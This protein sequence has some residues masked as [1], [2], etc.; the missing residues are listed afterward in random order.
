MLKMLYILQSKDF[1]QDLIIYGTIPIHL[2]SLYI[3]FIYM[4]T[5]ELFRYV[6][7]YDLLSVN[8]ICILIWHTYI[9]GVM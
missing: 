2:I 3:F 4:Y 1:N 6:F 8:A 5:T 9:V 7:L